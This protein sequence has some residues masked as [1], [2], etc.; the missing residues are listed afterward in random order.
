[1]PSDVSARDRDESATFSTFVVIGY[2]VSN[3]SVAKS[4]DESFSTVGAISIFVSMT[5][6]VSQVGVKNSSFLGHFISLLQRFDF[7]GW[8]VKLVGWIISSEV[9][10]RFRPHRLQVFLYHPS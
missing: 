8:V 9:Q 4:V 5:L 1:M 6:N 7:C 10:R 3:Y 2:P